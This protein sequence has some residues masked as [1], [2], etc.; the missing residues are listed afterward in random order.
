M[1]VRAIRSFVWQ[2]RDVDIGDEFDAAE[3]DAFLLIHGYGYCVPVDGPAPPMPTA[4]V[5]D[6]DPAVEH[7]DPVRAKARKGRP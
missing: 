6:R 7:R 1:R 4:M 2:L 3:R 5:V